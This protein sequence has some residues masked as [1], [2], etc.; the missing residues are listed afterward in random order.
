MDGDIGFEIEPDSGLFLVHCRGMWS[1]RQADAHF[2]AMETAIEAAR[3]TRRPVRVLVD[4]RG[5]RVQSQT[6]SQ[7]MAEGNTRIHRHT[8]RIA[9]VYDSALQALQV[10][11]DV[12]I[13]RIA[14]FESMEEARH[15]IE[16]GDTPP[17]TG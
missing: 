14:F 4:L 11:R 2:A 10:K 12:T 13:P 17:S 5:S 8:D 6:T 15:W 9:F 3:V 7:A 1:P 16:A